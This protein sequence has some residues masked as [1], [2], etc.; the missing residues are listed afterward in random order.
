MVEDLIERSR[1]PCLQALE[2]RGLDQV[3]EAILVGGTTRVPK[4]QQLVKDLFGKDP[5]KGVNPDEVVA[6]AATFIGVLTKS[7]RTQRDA[8]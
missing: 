4:V 2:D 8:T 7:V 1:G 3:D 5:H 6:V